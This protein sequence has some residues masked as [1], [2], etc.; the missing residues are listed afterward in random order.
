[1]E[2]AGIPVNGP[3][4]AGPTLAWVTVFAVAFAL[5]EA[6]VVMYLR[7]LYY[8]DGFAFPLKLI[9]GG[10]LRVEIAREA[11]TLVMLAAVGIVAGARPWEKFGYFIVAF[12]VWDALFYF[13]L[14]V[15]VGWPASLV[16]WDVLFLIP[17]PWVGPVIAPLLVSLLMV[18][19]GGVM[20]LRLSRDRRFKP[21]AVSW[22]LGALGTALVLLSFM[23]DTEAGLGGR[24][25]APYHYDLLLPG[26]AAY[27]C[28]FILACRSPRRSGLPEAA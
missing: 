7:A 17:V 14:V 18:V 25:P 20:V 9:P 3:R 21:G 28:G 15:M 27:A 24:M 23:I 5:V 6:S 12:G 4:R 10:Y 22:V 2:R 19:C 16:E 26:L 13:W 8:P 1:M 11:A